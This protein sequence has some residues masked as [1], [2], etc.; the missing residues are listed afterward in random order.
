MRRLILCSVCQQ[1]QYLE[2]KNCKFNPRNL[3]LFQFIL[4]LNSHHQESLLDKLLILLNKIRLPLKLMLKQR[5]LYSHHQAITFLAG[6]RLRH[7][8]YHHQRTSSLNTL[9]LWKAIRKQT[10]RINS[11]SVKCKNLLNNQKFCLLLQRTIHL[12]ERRSIKVSHHKCRQQ[13]LY[14]D[15]QVLQFLQASQLIYKVQTRKI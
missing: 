14:L 12:A 13:L 9:L 7:R 11:M 10:M 3:N 2:V 15:H 5:N 8:H 1:N 6:K 4:C